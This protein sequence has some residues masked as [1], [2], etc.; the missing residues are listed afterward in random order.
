MESPELS[1]DIRSFL[2]RYI[3]SIGQLEA[4]L[5][6]FRNPDETFSSLS[7]AQRLYVSD[8]S[9]IKI[10]KMLER[11]GLVQLSAQGYRYQAEFG[12]HHLVC[13]LEQG[14]ARH[15]IVITESIHAKSKNRIREF[16]SAFKLRKEK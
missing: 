1:A 12:Q 11:R 8:E 15:L 16:A 9:S 2:S 5:L 3:D 6:M 14:Y 4:L 10:L 7:L 13:E